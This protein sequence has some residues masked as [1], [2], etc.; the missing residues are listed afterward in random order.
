VRTLARINVSPVKGMALHHPDEVELGP[1]GIP[2]NRR[3]YLVDDS[4]ALFSGPTHGPLVRIRPDHDPAAR[5]LRLTFPEGLEVSG[6]TDALG[7]AVVTDFYGRPVSAHEVLGPFAEAVSTYVGKPLRLL[8]C[9]RD[10]D[11]VD[12]NPLTLVSQASVEDLVARG[13]RTEPLDSRRFRIN[14][15]LAG[16]E[17]YDED[18]W[19]G[20]R[21][22]IGEATVRIDGQIPRCVLTTMSPETG[23]KD[24][25][26]LTQIARY[27]PRI[28]GRGGLPF[29]VYA[30]VDTPGRVRLGDAVIPST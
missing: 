13:K 3:F 9:D 23:L 30:Q 28:G 11:G 10:G 7:A 22:R 20:Q 29:G 6:E 21:V 15:E 19:D 26:T 14:L 8:R 27:R 17:P 25:D 5:Q 2:E 16:C 18:S 1:E 24:W 4:G 12:V